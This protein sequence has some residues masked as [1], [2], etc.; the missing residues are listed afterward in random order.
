MKGVKKICKKV[1]DDLKKRSS[2]ILERIEGNFFR[3]FCLKVN[4]PKIFAPQYVTQIFAPNICDPN[5]CPPIFMT[6]LRLW[7]RA[8]VSIPLPASPLLFKKRTK[9]TSPILDVAHC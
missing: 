1:V 8:Y 2:E 6:S 4:L 9:L 7:L 5:F 3:F